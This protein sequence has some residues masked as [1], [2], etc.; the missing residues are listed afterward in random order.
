MT[1]AGALRTMRSRAVPEPWR[2]LRERSLKERHRPL[3]R[4]KTPAGRLALRLRIPFS[5]GFCKRT[6]EVGRVDGIRERAHGRRSKGGVDRSN[7]TQS[8][9]VISYEDEQI[10]QFCGA[11][12][13]GLDDFLSR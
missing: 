8:A 3:E 12:L 4:G 6:K 10:A 9:L 5:V 2:M 1:L 13:M 7:P 11:A